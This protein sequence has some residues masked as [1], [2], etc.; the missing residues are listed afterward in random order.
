MTAIQRLGVVGCGAVGSAVAEAAARAGLYVR[1]VEAH[2]AAVTAGR[3]RVE[4]S[5]EHRVRCGRITPTE[6]DLAL[7]RITFTTDLGDMAERQLVIEA[8]H[9][10]PAA[11]A[12]ILA[13][14]DKVLV[15]DNA[16]IATSTSSYPIADLAVATSRPENVLGTHIV[17]PAQPRLVVEV[18]PSRLTA[19][20]VVTQVARFARDRLGAA[21]V[22]VPDRSGFLV[23]ALLVPYLMSAVRMLESGVASIEDIDTGMEK[24]WS[25]P[26]GPLRLLDLV[27][28]DTATAIADAMSAEFQEPLYAPPPLLRRMVAVGH[29]GRKAG[30]GFYTYRRQDHLL[31]T[32]S[33]GGRR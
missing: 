7:G 22:Q 19:P 32:P 3:S 23:N 8:V 5:L 24:S 11:K 15:D 14:V 20:R 21:V 27:G 1:I 6:R 31:P 12:E 13:A 9:E 28:L 16:V 29:L 2:P 26:V 33:S 17:N 10:D 25:H 30:R 18:V 4:S